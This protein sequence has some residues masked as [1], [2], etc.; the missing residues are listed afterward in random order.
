MMPNEAEMFD[1]MRNKFIDIMSLPTKMA[2]LFNLLGIID[3]E[4]VRNFRRE[5]IK[6][7]M[8]FVLKLVDE[9]VSSNEDLELFTSAI[10][11]SIMLAPISVPDVIYKV[12]NQEIL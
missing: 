12:S 6:E 9:K 5:K 10:L 2:K 7:L 1:Q 3:L 8:P 11:E 4:E